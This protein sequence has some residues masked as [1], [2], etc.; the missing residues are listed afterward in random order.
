MPG[1]TVTPNKSLKLTGS[2][3]PLIARLSASANISRQLSSNVMPTT[4][5]LVHHWSSKITVVYAARLGSYNEPI[6][7]L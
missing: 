6:F 2:S 1:L 7:R 5:M 4:S 3:G